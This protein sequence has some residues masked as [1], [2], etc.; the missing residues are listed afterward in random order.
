MRLSPQDHVHL[1]LQP[2][3]CQTRFS[4]NAQPFIWSVSL[5]YIFGWYTDLL[6]AIYMVSS[7]EKFLLLI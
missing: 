3:L 6:I 5:V 1:E 2:A 4:I 7:L